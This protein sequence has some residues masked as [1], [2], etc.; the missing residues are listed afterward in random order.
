MMMLPVRRAPL[1]EATVKPTLPFP[2]PANGGDR[3]IQPTSLVAV[4]PQSVCVVTVTLPS[5]PPAFM[6]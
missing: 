3:L 2:L 6:L 4:H 1:L 5:S